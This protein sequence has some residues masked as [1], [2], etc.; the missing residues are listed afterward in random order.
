MRQDKKI[1]FPSGA[2]VS[3]IP[4]LQGEGAMKFDETEL[5]DVL[6][7][8]ALRN[9]VLFPGSI[10]PVTIGREKSMKL[11]QDAEKGGFFIGAVPQEDVMVE[12]PQEEDLFRYGSV[13]K[14]IKTL[15]MP[16]GTVTARVTVK[17]SGAMRGAEVV[18]LYVADATGAP[19]PGGRVPQALRRFAKIDLQPGEEREVVFT[20]TPQDISRYSPELH[21]WCAAPG[22]Y[23]IRIGHSS[24]DIRAVLALQYTD[25]KI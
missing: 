5:P 24:R 25:A 11:I 4:V 2:E 1:T 18:Q 22:R 19:V 12:E 17:N 7:I 16:D 6:P 8:L 20:L 9:A 10:Y 21:A 14:I 23:E 13:C 15:E 3:I